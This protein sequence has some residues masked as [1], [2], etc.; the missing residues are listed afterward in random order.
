M[1]DPHAFADG[2]DADEGRGRSY[3]RGG[4]RGKEGDNWGEYGLDEETLR[5]YE[6]RYAKDRELEKRPTLGGSVLSA[7]G[8]LGSRKRE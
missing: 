7:I 3:S 5:Q 1:H 8:F 2:E 4:G 6:K